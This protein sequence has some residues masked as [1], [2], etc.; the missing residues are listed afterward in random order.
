MR[1]SASVGKTLQEIRQDRHSGAAE[2]AQKG[3]K[4]LLDSLRVASAAHLSEEIKTLGRALID[5]QPAMA[6]MLNLVNHLFH[7][8]DSLEDPQEIREK[9]RAAVQGFLDSL[10]T[11]SEKIR[12]HAFPLLKGKRR[13]MTL[14]YSSTALRVLEG[15][16]GI[17]V[18]CPESRPLSEGLRTAKE[19]GAKGIKV[20]VVTDFAA[21]S[22]VKESDLVMVG[23]DAITLDGVVNK[24]GTYGLALAAKEKKIPFYVLA[25][26]EKFLPPPFAQ[27]LRIEKKDPKEITKETMPHVVVENVYFDV[28]PLDLIT[29]VVTQQGVIAGS[30]VR[31]LLQGMRI[32]KG[33]EGP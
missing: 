26:T 6:P 30:E 27:A 17:E 5:A 32:N 13:V 9:G 21:L 33:L 28:T 10:R 14:S 15:A 22:L 25:G 7:A 12:G 24:I 18:I 1:R 2:L 3:A 29:G 4:L 11:A 31:R 8:I 19:L 20:R 16:R 23:A